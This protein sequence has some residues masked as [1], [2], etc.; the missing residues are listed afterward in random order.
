MGNTEEQNIEQE[1]KFKEL[2]LEGIHM[3]IT[4]DVPRMKK[5]FESFSCAVYPNYHMTYILLLIFILYLK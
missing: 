4:D 3:V 5:L 2:H 1:E